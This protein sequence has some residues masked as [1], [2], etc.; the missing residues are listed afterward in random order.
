MAGRVKADAARNL[1]HGKRGLPSCFRTLSVSIEWKR[2]QST[3]AAPAPK[4][5][6]LSPD[7][8]FEEKRL[9]LLQLLPYTPVQNIAGA[10]GISVPVGK[11]STG[12]PIGVQLAGPKG[13]ERRL[14]ELAFALEEHPSLG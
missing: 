7:Q 5:G 2:Q 8:E 6:D 9:K 12:L 13:G 14:S 4:I 11:T 10:P 3:T 1:S